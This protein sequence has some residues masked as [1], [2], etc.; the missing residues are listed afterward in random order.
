M[1]LA[2]QVTSDDTLVTAAL[3]ANLAALAVAVAELRQAQ[4]HAAQAAA[5]RAAGWQLH[6]A[7]VR[8]RSPVLRQ[9]R[10]EDRQHSRPQTPADV[11]HGDFPARPGPDHPAP[12]APSRPRPRPDRELLPRRAG[13]GR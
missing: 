4:Q 9:H 7:C 8:D 5:A 6:A 10:A 13:R 12:A 11:A 2:G 1:A 3:I